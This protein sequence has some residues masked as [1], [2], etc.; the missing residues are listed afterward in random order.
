MD[1]KQILETL[2]MQPLSEEE[3]SARHILG[4]LAGPIATCKE[5]TRNGRKYNRQLWENALND[6][7]F[8]EKIANKSLF[9][10][11]GHPTDR[12]EID[13]RQV[14]ACIPEVP[15]I[16]NDDLYAYVDILDTPNGK[17]LK[18]LCDY[19][20][21]PGISSRGSGDIIGDDE[22]DPD[23]FYLETWDIVATPAVK[24]ARLSVCEGLDTSAMKLKQALTESYKAASEEDQKIMQEGLSNL[25]IKLDEAV[26]YAAVLPE[27][28]VPTAEDE[29]E[30]LVEETAEA[31]VEVTEEPVAE[32]EEVEDEVSEDD[33]PI[34]IPEEAAEF[35]VKQLKTNLADYDDDLEIVFEPIV[36]DDKT[37]NV[38][39]MSYEP[40]DENKLHITLDY[41]SAMSDN[42]EDTEEVEDSEVKVDELTVN[43][44][45]TSDETEIPEEEVID[46]EAAEVIE[47][48]K[49]ITRQKDE[50]E[51]EVKSLKKDKTVSDAEVANLKEELNRY[52]LSFARTSALAA[53]SKDL[54]KENQTLAESLKTKE[55]QINQLKA[56][57]SN[58]QALKEST[59]NSAQR[60]KALTENLHEVQKTLADADNKLKEQAIQY[61]AKLTESMNAT[62]QYKAKFNLVL[63]HYIDYRASM[64]GVSTSEITSKLNESYSLEDI[65]AVCDKLLD[66]GR[67]SLPAGLTRNSR[68]S[69]KESVEPKK[70]SGKN[71]GYEI[72]DDLLELAGLKKTF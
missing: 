62:K 1:N 54:E 70:L 52:K 2:Q 3:K 33:I 15:K 50:L 49:E 6:E 44:E 57:Q 31:D 7:L 13:M 14:C 71:D 47:S 36:I 23:T 25:N 64:L 51:E 11:L 30:V 35:T 69:I 16:A 40:D 20:F 12:E 72:D 24:K 45:Q 32:T 21:I 8:E 60:I 4:R 61:K 67:S 17:I 56:T 42:I 5:S 41:D 66:C 39:A 43:G 63:T 68:V 19:G 38:T 9:L 48:I 26:Q 37:L 59:D 65:D 22:V 10:E 46:D 58:A 18:T 27:E 29:T 28:E 53:K 34:E 55:A